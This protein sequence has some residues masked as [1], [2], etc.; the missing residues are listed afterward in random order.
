MKHACRALWGLNIALGLGAVTILLPS[1]SVDRLIDVRTIDATASRIPPE[2]SADESVLRL[3]NPVG[4]P[5]EAAAAFRGFTLKGALPGS[6]SVAFMRSVSRPVDLMASFGEGIL[7]D[8]KPD[9]EFEGWR[10]LDVWKDRAVFVHKSGERFEVQIESPQPK[11]PSPPAA[12]PY[13]AEA[14]KSRLLA[15]TETREVW[16]VDEKEAAWAGRNLAAMLERDVVL[17]PIPGLGLRIEALTAGSMGAA[18]GLK[19]GDLLSEVNGRPVG[20]LSDLR[21][22][23]VDPPKST[24]RL[25]LERNGRPHVLEYHPLPR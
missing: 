19:P 24:L 6:T 1:S 23:L 8:G 7:Q 17:T 11:E 2:P 14:Y 22:L 20:N 16:G 10:L 12:E 4:A 18:R 5:K 3:G 9:P 25:G 15:S 13:R 21:Q